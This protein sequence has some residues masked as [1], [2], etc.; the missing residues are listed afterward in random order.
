MHILLDNAATCT[1]SQLRLAGGSTSYEG[2]VEVC[3]SSGAWSTV[4]GIFWDVNDATV[5]CRQLG[6][7]ARGTY[8]VCI[9]KYSAFW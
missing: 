7:S 8:R 5:V 1:E 6:F 2:R 3:S 9:L 4:C